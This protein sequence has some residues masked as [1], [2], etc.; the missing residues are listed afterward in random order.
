MTSRAI[1]VTAALL[2]AGI[3]P[4]S[5]DSVTGVV[6]QWN[7][8]TRTITLDDKSQFMSIP[9]EVAVPDDLQD[10]DEIAVENEAFEDGVDSYVSI[11]IVNKNRKS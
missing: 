8:V 1:F 2:V 9:K 6:T 5:A 7:K 3:V 4:A 10:G 11:K